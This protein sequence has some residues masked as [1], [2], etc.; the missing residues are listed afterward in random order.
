MTT[1]LNIFDLRAGTS[2]EVLRHDGLIEAPNWSPDGRYLL[3]N[4]EGRLYRVPLERPEM[5][6][7]DT[8]FATKCN[9]DHGI[10]PD[11]KT[12]AITDKVETGKS[13]IYTLPSTGGAPTRIT[14]D[15]PS[16]WHGWSPDGARLTYTAL[17]DGAFDIFTCPVEG[18]AET[19]LTCDF[20]HT[21][22]PDYTPGGDWIWFN[23]MRDGAMELWRVRIEGENLEQMTDDAWVNWFPHPSPDGQSVLFLSY[24]SGDVS[25]PHDHPRD[26]DVA[27]RL[28]P[29]KGGTPTT[30]LEIFGGQGTIN[31]PCW[32][33]DGTQFAYVDVVSDA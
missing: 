22:G 31:V 18:G 7:V 24:A 32:A 3:I 19:K 14:M 33:P 2:R 26:R 25:A 16:Y 10:S 8:G 6:L 28:M 23:G 9:N 11:G 13:C 30:L 21:D 12:F 17:R 20:D 15:V 4:S 27:L 5:Q 29:A 1:R